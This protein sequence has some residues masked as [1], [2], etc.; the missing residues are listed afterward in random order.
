MEYISHF[1]TSL[2]LV[3]K[4]VGKGGNEENCKRNKP[5]AKI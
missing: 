4:H 3:P 1:T 2:R 5:R